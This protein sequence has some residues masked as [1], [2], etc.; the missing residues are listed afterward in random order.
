MGKKIRLPSTEPAVQM[1][2]YVKRLLW[3]HR[4]KNMNHVSFRCHFDNAAEVM[5]LLQKEVLTFHTPSLFQGVPD[6]DDS[7]SGP[8]AARIHS[9]QAAEGDG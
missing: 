9:P 1:A 4:M 7:Q 6:D 2:R 5:D 3:W 8:A